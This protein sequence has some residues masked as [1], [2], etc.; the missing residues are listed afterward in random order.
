MIRHLTVLPL[1]GGLLVACTSVS[2]VDK[3]IASNLA[4]RGG[5]EKIQALRSIRESGRVTASDGR[6]AL[7]M[8]EIK[9]PRLLRLE[10][11]YQGTVSVFANDG[12]T[13]WQI[14]PLQGQFEPQEV[15]PEIDSA[16][17]ADQGDLEGPLVGWK[18]K[19][20]VVELV[21]RETLPGGEAFKLKVTLKGGSIRYDYIDVATRLVV[22]T[23]TTRMV[24][25]HAV[26]LESS[27]SDFR[28]VGGLVFPHVI[29]THIKDRPRTLRIDVEKIELNPEIDDARFKLPASAAGGSEGS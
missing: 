11:T 29:E 2:P 3:V 4:A 15:P 6:V 25:G 8:R 1:L 21:G 24:R 16:G 22:R 5:R 7:V 26:W 27:F 17:S 28:T 19:G 14:A 10:F 9:R 20:H 13:G 18:E 23:D 12:Q